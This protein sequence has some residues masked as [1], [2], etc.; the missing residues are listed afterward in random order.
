MGG[1]VAVVAHTQRPRQLFPPELP[2]A[3]APEVN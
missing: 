3:A 2:F 1:M